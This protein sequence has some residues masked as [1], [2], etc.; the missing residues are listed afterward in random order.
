MRATPATDPPRGTIVQ[1]GGVFARV[2]CAQESFDAKGRVVVR[3]HRIA[4]RMASRERSLPASLRSTHRPTV[5][6]RVRAPMLRFEPEASM[7]SQWDMD[8]QWRDHE[9]HPQLVADRVSAALGSMQCTTPS[10]APRYARRIQHPPSNADYA[11][12]W[13]HDAPDVAN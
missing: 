2:E 12:L 3:V 8:A 4:M 1:L 5:R 10:G 13:P 11:A 9:A 7:T 6:R